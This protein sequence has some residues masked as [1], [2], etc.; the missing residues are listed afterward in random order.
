ML[1]VWRTRKGVIGYAG[2]GMLWKEMNATLQERKW[3]K[4]E[5]IVW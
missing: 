3:I 5:W 1:I 4:D 2:M